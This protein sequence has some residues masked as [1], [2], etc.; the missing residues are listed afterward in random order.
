MVTEYQTVIGKYKTKNTSNTYIT[1]T[2]NIH[3][4]VES[5]YIF[6]TTLELEIIMN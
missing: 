5:K 4:Q 2:R 1:E 6:C 3:V